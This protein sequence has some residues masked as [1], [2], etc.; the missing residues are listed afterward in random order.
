[1]PC[2][3]STALSDALFGSSWLAFDTCE[4]VSFL[5]NRGIAISIYAQARDAAI[6]RKCE[7][8][9]AGAQHAQTVP[10]LLRQFHI[11]RYVIRAFVCLSGC[12]HRAQL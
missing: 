2:Q 10:Q 6:L 5:A 7:K 8:I 9:K 3:A 11:P 1:M 12:R 4:P